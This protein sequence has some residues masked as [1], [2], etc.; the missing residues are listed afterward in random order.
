MRF[1]GVVRFAEKGS[2]CIKV[3]LGGGRVKYVL[4]CYPASNRINR[5][6]EPYYVDFPP[7]YILDEYDKNTLFYVEGDVF[8]T[9]NAEGNTFTSFLV[10]LARCVHKIEVKDEKEV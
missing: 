10:D 3:D 7:G 4:K 1:H 2:D 8:C 6:Y 9:K 5:R